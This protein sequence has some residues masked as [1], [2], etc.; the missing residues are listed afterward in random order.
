MPIDEMKVKDIL[1]NQHIVRARINKDVGTYQDF[2]D[3]TNFENGV[4]T[5][6]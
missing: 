1:R 2:L 4:L 3:R 6:M 5:Y